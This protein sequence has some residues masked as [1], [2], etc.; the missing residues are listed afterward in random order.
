MSNTPEIAI[1]RDLHRYPE[2]A[3]LEYRTASRVAET[4]D[5]LGYEVRTGEAVMNPASVSNPPSEEAAAEAVKRALST[6]GIAH[7]IEQMHGGLTAVVAEKRFGDGPVLAFRFDMDAL[8]L[9][10]TEAT[11]HGPN[12]HGCASTDPERMHGCGHDGHVAIGLTLARTL[13]EMQGLGGTV[14]F[15]FQPAEEGGRGAVP[16]IDAG[17]LDDVDFLFVAHLGC[18]LGSGKV[19]PDASGFL[20][21]TKFEVTFEGQASHA[22]MA[23]QEGRNALMAG[24]TA[25]L[26]L[27]GISRIAGED[28]FVNVGKMSGGT[29]FNIIAD[30][31][32]MAVE[33][34]AETT[35]GHAYMLERAEAIIA[36]AA[37]LH[38]ASHEMRIVSQLNGNWNHP[39]ALAI[40]DRAARSLSDLEVVKSWPIGG[41]D[42]ASKMIARVNE[43]GGVAAYF[44]IGS[45]ITAPHHAENF[46]FDE[47]SLVSGRR[48][49]EAIAQEILGKALTRS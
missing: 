1:R 40:I 15:I 48:V 21:S 47:A 24:A 38:A 37:Q 11:D 14:R 43:R 45:D 20:H 49:F 12:Q 29:T 6:G 4:L 5:G 8:T 17:V 2:T 44:L 9:V 7:W 39:D 25:L 46:D 19:A 10:E 22:A 32:E 13:A 23:P 28:S 16:I 33:V 34:R 27:Q 35:A 26:N 3:F 41:G 31:C 30:H 42:D 36:G 18:F